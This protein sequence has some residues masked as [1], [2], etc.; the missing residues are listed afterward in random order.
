MPIT[1]KD[2]TMKKLLA[3]AFITTGLCVAAA[4]HTPDEN[5]GPT[6]N[7][8]EVP[9][10]LRTDSP[11]V[12]LADSLWNEPS[13]DLGEFV[14]TGVAAAVVA[15]EDTV[16]YNAGS[17]KTRPNATVEDLLKKLP[18][19]E[20]SSDGS[21]SANGKTVSKILVDGKEFFGDDY[22]MASQNITSDMVEK[23]QVVDRK[24][25]LSR[26]TG[27]DD[28]EEETV[29]N[30]K[31][32]KCMKNGWFGDIS[33]GYGTDGRYEGSFNVSNFTGANQISIV[34]GANNINEL[35]FS[36]AGRGRFRDM[37]QSRGITTAQ[38]LGINF[39]VG[40]TERFRVGGNV[41]YTHSDRDARSYSETQ[42]LFPDSVSRLL[43][44]NRS[45]DRGHN[46]RADFRL[47]WKIDSLNTLEFRP[48]FSL[49]LRHAETTDTSRLYAGDVA[50][51]LVNSNESRRFNRGTSWNAGGNLIFNHNFRNRPGRSF[52][53]QARYSFSD[54]RQH[55]TTWND[56]AYYLH[57]EDS[58]LLYR[59]LED[60]QWSNTV[61]GRLTWTEPIGDVKKGN[62]L[63]FV[64]RLKYSF[65]NSDKD[66]YNLPDPGGIDHVADTDEVPAGSEFNSALSNRFRNT[67]S[68]HEL[69]IGYKKVNSKY[70]LEAGIVVSPSSSKSTDLINS[71]RNI[72]TRWV[73]N[74]A[75]YARFRYK[76]SKTKS[77]AA[78]YRAR[79]S[80]PSIASLQPVADVSDPLHITVGNPDLKPSYTQ[81]V[82]L[83]FNNYNTD[84][85]QSL[86]ASMFGQYTQNVT[87]SR[88][89]TDPETGV[90]NTTYA[91]ANGNASVMGMFMLTQPLRNRKFRFNVRAMGNF[92][93]NA[94]YI[95]GDFNRTGNLRLS[96][97]F[98][99]TFTSDVF[100]MTVNPTYSFNL[101]TNSLPQQKNRYL[102]TYGFTTDAHLYL[103]FGLNIST[104]L[105]FDK[106]SGYSQGFNTETWMWNA[107]LSYSVLSDKSL[108]FSIRAYDLLGMNR[109]V[110]RSVTANTIVDSRYNDLTR[111]VM[112]GVSWSFNTM[113]K[114]QKKA[115]EEL[116]GEMPPPP[117]D[118]ERP[119]G[120]PPGGGS[121]G[122]GGPAGPPPF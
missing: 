99:F 96:P 110:S 81:S 11:S 10:S 15:K 42:Y 94:G 6:S 108:T 43:S 56:I 70:N 58:E 82:N 86:F 71:E 22:T 19:V 85:Q 33:A 16:E 76:F 106:S 90:R 89:V 116:P 36:D 101:T 24:S 18:G 88:T 59:Y 87:V 98:G 25:D 109:D 39:S 119:A 44:G 69:R 12:A 37:G 8:Q 27:V 30:L 1:L 41:F 104:D 63:Q 3:L 72:D 103:P 14:V 64:Y 23:V 21:I 75:P 77:F 93:S 78:D 74:V 113:K 105:S 35:G 54:T 65:N 97:T 61:E 26:L 95:D 83:H 40:N 38:R 52:S 100:Q 121:G 5:P 51:T 46:L 84:K 50:N 32:K 117:G 115:D 122:H 13:I 114:K 7:S 107:E 79:S 102:H 20:V 28:G 57:Q 120:P 60:H 92:S 91:N 47:Q 49:N 4:S 48:N 73:W 9:D 112:F 34:G 118:G 29:I 53:V 45:N 17:Y 67:F 80:S 31:V 62:F 55:S 68:T 2:S 111:Y 66:T